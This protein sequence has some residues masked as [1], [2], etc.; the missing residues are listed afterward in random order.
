MVKIGKNGD[1]LIVHES[2]VDEHISLGWSVIEYD[3]NTEELKDA[4]KDILQ[5]KT[6]EMKA[7]LTE[8]G[9]NFNPQAKKDELS[10]LLQEALKQA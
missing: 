3:E 1:L 4:E 8:L 5:L 6:S 10:V 7:K 9:V 2:T